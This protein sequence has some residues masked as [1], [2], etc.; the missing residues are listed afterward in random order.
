MSENNPLNPLPKS[1]VIRWG[2]WQKDEDR[3]LTFPDDWEVRTCNLVDAPALSDDAIR[4][5]LHNP[6]GTPRIAALARKQRDAVIVV[7]DLSRPTPASHV[8]PALLEELAEGGITDD[9]VTII[10][11]VAT[12]RPLIRHEIVQKIGE[13]IYNRIPVVNHFAWE[14]CAYVGTTSF[15]TPVY[16]NRR[17]MNA[18]VKICLGGILPHSGAGFGGGAKLLMP[19]VAGVETIYGNHG[20]S[21]RLRGGVNVI[22]GN[23]FRLD[24]EEAARLAHLDVI[25][26]TVINSRR[27]VAALFVG[28]CVEAHRVGVEYARNI[29][30]TP[31]PANWDVAVMSCYPKDTEFVQAGMGL[32]PWHTAHQPLVHEQGTVVLVSA[33]PEGMGYHGL[34]GADMRLGA[35]GGYRR[36]T[37][38]RD[39]VVYCPTINLHDFAPE[40][41]KDVVLCKRWDEVTSYLRQKHGRGTKCVVFPA[42]AMQLAD[43]T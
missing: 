17:F 39:F 37:V 2:A 12:H 35:R 32:H 41:R 42:G 23:E 14:N 34:M 5:A 40:L 1:A 11:G 30:A 9:R 15:G 21:Q 3:V 19:G 43:Q 27:E 26:N 38:D 7:D 24:I 22:D 33:A 25:V 18:G 6:V 10:V 28:D 31:T 13:D 29:Y 8:L 16:I 36:P 4:Q 20:R